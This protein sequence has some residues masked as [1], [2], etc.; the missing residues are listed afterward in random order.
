MSTHDWNNGGYAVRADELRPG[1]VIDL[2]PLLEHYAPEI[3]MEHDVS[4]YEY[5]TVERVTR[6]DPVYGNPA[7][8]IYTDQHNVKVPAS[9]QVD[10]ER[11]ASLDD[12]PGDLTDVLVQWVNGEDVTERRR[13]ARTMARTVLS[14]GYRRRAPEVNL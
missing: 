12:E 11:D 2:A 3:D 9:A 4:G 6:A 8:L 5:A 14:A 10:Q 7:V 1:D 13:T